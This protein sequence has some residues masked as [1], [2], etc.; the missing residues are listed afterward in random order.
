MPSSAT[1]AAERH[2]EASMMKAHRRGMV[3]L[4]Y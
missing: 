1:T 4:L 3:F 2:S